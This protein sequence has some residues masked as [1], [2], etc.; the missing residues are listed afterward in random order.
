MF[1]YLI[2]NGIVLNGIDSEPIRQNVVIS[3]DRI[4][5]LGN[6]EIPS[7]ELIDA[8]GLYVAPGFI[9]VHAHSEF[10]LLLDG[11]A[12]GKLTQGITTEINGNCGLSAAPLYGEAFEHRLQEL[13]QLGINER[14]HELDE[15]LKIL[16]SK[17]IA[18]NFA[19][20]CGHGN[21]R[22]S[23]IG[24]ANAP[25]EGD[26]LDRMK[27]LFHKAVIQGACGLSTG[28][29][30]P[31]GIY[32]DTREI[33]GLMDVVA[34]ESKKHGLIPDRKFLYTSHIRS[35]GDRL[36]EAIEEVIGI[37][38]EAGANVHISHIKTSGEQN[39]WKI[40]SV[41]NMLEEARNSGVGITCDSYPYIAS[42]TDL[43]TV[44]PAWT[45]A[46]GLKEELRRLKDPEK[47]QKIRAELSLKGDE[48]W[49]NVYVSSIRNP[50][51]KWMEGE[52]IFDIASRKKK[53]PADM[54]VDIIIDEKATAGAIFF[55]MNE[56]NLRRLLS[57]PYVMIGSD[58]SA[59]SFSGP[60][61]KGKP[62]PRGFGTFPKFIGT[63]VRDENL[64]PLPEAVRRITS[65][66]AGTFGIKERGIIK[67]GFFADIII[68]N[69][70]KISA[71]ATY[72]EPFTK[73]SGIEYVFVNGSLAVSKGELTGTC[74]G[75]VL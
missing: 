44:L 23:V 68:F 70:N 29:V 59:R 67:E 31:P 66:P 30:Y 42:S 19:T 52:S 63:Y 36:L 37:A 34:S 58:S 45:F 10:N 40:D 54:V 17:G 1:D 2:K 51:S 75:R 53:V 56:D 38:K 60:T 55:T 46:G 24:Y 8:E 25:C 12:E 27:A 65:L 50:V 47:C 4:V 14:W 69:Y 5:Y 16:Q 3:G 9:D 57:L 62:H 26:M 28:L 74:H 11:R 32:S 73:S 49:K 39:W 6:K 43:D 61:F 48:Y 22:A 64:M 71:N 13:E 20:L 15:Y 18:L 35:E 33:I 41:V 72:K 7:G 21:L